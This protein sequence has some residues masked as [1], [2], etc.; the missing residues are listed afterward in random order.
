[1]LNYIRTLTKFI[2]GG[3]IF[4]LK[5]KKSPEIKRFQDFYG[6]LVRNRYD[7][8]MLYFQWVEDYLRENLALFWGEM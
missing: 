2:S 8:E 5:T 1:M 4:P 6:K 7:A 3:T